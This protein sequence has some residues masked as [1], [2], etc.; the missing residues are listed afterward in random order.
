MI[1]VNNWTPNYIGDQIP[2][3]GG[4]NFIN[5]YAEII[6]ITS[7]FIAKFYK[8]WGEELN[9]PKYKVLKEGGDREEGRDNKKETGD[10]AEKLSGGQKE[11]GQGAEEIRESNL[12]LARA[13]EIAAIANRMAAEANRLSAEAN[14]LSAVAN[15]KTATTNQRLAALLLRKGKGTTSD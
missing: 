11:T 1:N 3:V 15:N 4:A 6:T 9:L 5:Y 7:R 14:R 8:R 12:V 10:G 13:N 2:K